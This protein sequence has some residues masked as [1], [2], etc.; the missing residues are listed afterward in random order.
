MIWFRASTR[1]NFN[2]ALDIKAREK[3]LKYSKYDLP[4]Q[5]FYPLPFGRTNILSQ[6]IFDFCAFIDRHFPPQFGVDRNLRA[7]LSRAIC[8][9]VAHHFNIAL[10]RLQLAVTARVALPLVPCAAGINPLSL[11]L[12]QP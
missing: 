11:G 7:T 12:Q 3:R 5:H 4:A 2:A 1:T 10:R 8:V 9:G 6:E